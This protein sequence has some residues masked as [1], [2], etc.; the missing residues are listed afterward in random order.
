MSIIVAVCISQ[1][2]P[3]NW[4]KRGKTDGGVFVQFFYDFDFF[5]LQTQPVSSYTWL[6]CNAAVDVMWLCL[7]CV[8]NDWIW[9]TDDYIGLN[10]RI[11]RLLPVAFVF[12]WRC[13]LAVKRCSLYRKRWAAIVT[14]FFFLLFFSGVSGSRWDWSECRPKTLF[15]LPMLR[16][17]L[18]NLRGLSN[19][20][21]V[22]WCF[23][24]PC[25]LCM[26][27]MTQL[28]NFIHSFMYDYINHIYSSFRGHKDCLGSR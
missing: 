23:I 4:K 25:G 19:V 28:W 15:I 13:H 6:H 11:S 24:S 2:S 16:L 3:A 8:M 14:V 22:C 10:V 26:Q 21:G 17:S 12:A 27:S 18:M 5:K 9:A 20:F 1:S 7:L